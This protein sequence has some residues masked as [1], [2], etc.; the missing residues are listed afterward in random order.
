MSKVD[1]EGLRKITEGI[2]EFILKK[3]W[4]LQ[5]EI[6]NYDFV[7]RLHPIT[8]QLENYIKNLKSI[9]RSMKK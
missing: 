1:I 8:L 5:N 6:D 3:L 2:E 4:D 9:Y 7:K